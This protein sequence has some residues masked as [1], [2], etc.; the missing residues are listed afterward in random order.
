MITEEMIT[1]AIQKWFKRPS[2]HEAFCD[3]YR[4]DMRSALEAVL[5][6]IEKE[7]DEL[8]EKTIGLESELDITVDMILAAKD[9]DRLKETTL[10]NFPKKKEQPDNEGWIEW[11]RDMQA[12]SRE[13]MVQVKYIDGI[14]SKPVLAIKPQWFHCGASDMDI[15]AYRILP[16]QTPEKPLA[17]ITTNQQLYAFAEITEDRIVRNNNGTLSTS[18]KILDFPENNALGSQGKIKVCDGCQV[19]LYKNVCECEDFRT[20]KEKIPTLNEYLSLPRPPK[21]YPTMSLVSEYLDK[22]MMEK[23]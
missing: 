6:L 18:R 2:A 8:H 21:V 9:L 5:S 11:N 13:L 23:G 16:N 14:I 19:N 12:P 3:D 4:N 15:I 22:Y 17:E 7:V 10:M 20:E 1:M